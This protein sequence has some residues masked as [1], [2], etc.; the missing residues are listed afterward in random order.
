VTWGDEARIYS[1]AELAGGVNL[2]ADFATNPFSEAFERVDKAVAAKQ[3]YETTQIKKI[4]HGDEG[5]QDMEAAAKR[6]EAERAP[7]AEAIRAAFVP[8][9]HELRIE[10]VK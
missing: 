4:F 6:T 10:A 9:R 1:A 7:L 3:A 2:A 8:V 5:R